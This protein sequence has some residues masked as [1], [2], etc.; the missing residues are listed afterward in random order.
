MARQDAKTQR[1]AVE[2]IRTNSSELEADTGAKIKSSHK[3]LTHSDS[4]GT[5]SETGRVSSQFE[6]LKSGRRYGAAVCPSAGAF[7]ERFV[8]KTSNI[9]KSLLLICHAALILT[10]LHCT[11]LILLCVLALMPC[12]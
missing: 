4:E 6:L 7:T 5:K 10:V 2:Q 1:E 11:R 3:F 12:W 8:P 9:L